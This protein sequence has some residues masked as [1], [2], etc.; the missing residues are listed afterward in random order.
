M[1]VAIHN[2]KNDERERIS[3]TMDNDS[4]TK[5]LAWLDKPLKFVTYEII[6]YGM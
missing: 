4:P 2:S 5:T 3:N 6:E 1:A